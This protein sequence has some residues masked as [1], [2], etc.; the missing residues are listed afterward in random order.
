MLWSHV[1]RSVGKETDKELVNKRMKEEIRQ[2]PQQ[3]KKGILLNQ[4]FS[5]FSVCRHNGWFSLEK[6]TAWH[7]LLWEGP[8]QI[9]GN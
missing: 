4:I 1:L 3:R 7:F 2:L 8:V 5:S 6:L 9:R